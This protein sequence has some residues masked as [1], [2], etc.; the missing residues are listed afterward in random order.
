MKLWH[1][2]DA[3]HLSKGPR[4]KEEATWWKMT[5]SMSFIRAA[6]PGPN[7]GDHEDRADRK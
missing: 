7:H 3:C 5:I 2:I 1:R 4:F 6:A